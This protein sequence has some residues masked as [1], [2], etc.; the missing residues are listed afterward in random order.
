LTEKYMASTTRTRTKYLALVGAAVV[1]AGVLIL[2]F[3]GTLPIS[4]AQ[5]QE[6]VQAQQQ[7]DSAGQNGTTTA[8]AAGGGGPES[9]LIAFIPQ[10]VTINAGQTVVWTNPMV[11]P[12]PHTVSFIRQEGYFANF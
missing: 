9:V 2:A 6:Q 12:E 1:A 11:V 7:A 4:S 8:V 5:P 3:T 10:N